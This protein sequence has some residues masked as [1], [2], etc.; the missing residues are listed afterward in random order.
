MTLN[1]NVWDTH[2]LRD[3]AQQEYPDENVV[4]Y[5]KKSF[6]TSPGNS[7]LDLGTGSGR[8]L[9]L[10]K[11]CFHRV[12][13]CDYSLRALQLTAH[14]KIDHVV[15][16]RTLSVLPDLPFANE[17]FDFVLCWGVIHYLDSLLHEK[18][19]AEIHRILKLNGTVLT[20][21][22]S[23]QDSHLEKQFSKG[24]LA[25]G[26]A[27]LFSKEEALTLTKP[28]SNTQYGFILRQPLGESTQV[29]HH[30]LCATK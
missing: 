21:L 19:F 15:L 29:A 18:A 11:Q 17:S 20:T 14:K 5:L 26:R 23:D 10:L 24:D 3:H 1:R 25:S 2:Y 7:A 12:A 27:K 30:I 9:P 6:A 16:G 22:R 28:F 4:R 8:H 13:A